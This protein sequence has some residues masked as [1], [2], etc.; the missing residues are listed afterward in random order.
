M[1][2]RQRGRDV[3]GSASRAVRLSRRRPDLSRRQHGE[4]EQLASCYRT[5]LELAEQRGLRSISFPAISTGAYGYPADEAAR[6]AFETVA[7]HLENPATG[8]REVLFVM[9]DQ[10]FYELYSN[11]AKP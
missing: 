1:P 10:G 5:C 2:H 11:V 8:L 4:P 6:I 7:K 9:F 3:G